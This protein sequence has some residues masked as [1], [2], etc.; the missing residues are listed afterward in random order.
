MSRLQQWRL[1]ALFLVLLTLWAC[2]PGTDNTNDGN[3][4]T[5]TAAVARSQSLAAEGHYDEA[6][7]H[8]ASTPC[9]QTQIETGNLQARL[10]RLP[11]AVKAYRRALQEH[12]DHAET[13]HNLAVVLAD[14]GQHPEAVALLEETLEQH[15]S[16][17]PAQLTLALLY[18]KEGRY[19][20]AEALLR[21]GAEADSGDTEFLWQLGKLLTRRGQYDQAGAY[22]RQAVGRDSTAAE[23]WRLLGQLNAENGLHTKAVSAFRRALGINPGLIEAHY[24]LSKSLFTLGQKAQAHSAVRRFETLSNHAAHTAHLRRALDAEPDDNDIRLALAYHYTRLEKRAAA[25]LQY[26]AILGQKPGSIEATLGLARLLIQEGENDRALTLCSQAAQQNAADPDLYRVVY[27]AGEAHLAAGRRQAARAAFT[28]SLALK[29]EQAAAWNRL[30]QLHQAENK[31][32]ATLEAFE[33][34]AQIDPSFAEAHLHLGQARA[35]WGDL[36]GAISA[37]NNAVQADSTLAQAYFE[38]GTLYQRQ[39]AASAA[40]AAFQAFLAHWNGATVQADL[41]RAHLARLHQDS[42]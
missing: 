11:A 18:V 30:G 4:T 26:Q 1:P 13:R 34:A 9:L 27:T 23:A 16:F 19:E 10:G 2:T 42:P 40:T 35:R 25:R 3:D 32:A 6:L 20:P 21:Q 8:L 33:R 37:L 14:Q 29:P 7:N 38:L 12:P 22:L 41:A 17:Q 31:P 24:N 39:N 36:K 28:R 15:P 5:C